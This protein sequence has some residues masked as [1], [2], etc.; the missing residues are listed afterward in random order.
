[1]IKIKKG[2]DLP[3][4]GHPEQT[5]YDGQKCTKVAVL[6]GDYVGMKPTIKVKVGDQVKKGDVLFIDKKFPEIHFTSPGAGKVL[7]VNRGKRRVFE[8]VVIEL[9]GS[10]GEVT[11]DS[12]NSSELEGLGLEKVKSNL[13]KS[14]LW[15]LLKTRPFSKV[16]DPS[17]EPNSIFINT[18]DTNPLAADPTAVIGEKK[19]AFINGLKVISNLT[20]GKKYLC[21]EAGVSI[22]GSELSFLDVKEFKGVHPA[23]NTGTHI[24]FIDPVSI[25]KTVWSIGYQSVISIGELFTTGKICV[26]RVVALSG[27]KVEKPRLVRTRCGAK[28]SE[29]L[30]NQLKSG[31][32]RIISGSVLNGRSA[33]S[34]FDYLG[35]FHN[36]VTVISEGKYREFLGWVMPGKNKFSVKNIFLSSIIPS[37]NFDFSTNTNG[38]ER[39]MVPIGSYEKVMPLDILPTFL[40][41]ALITLDTDYAQELGCLELDEEDLALCTFVC[42][43]KYEYGSILRANLNQIEKDG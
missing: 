4:M 36:Q 12:F 25:D 13:L 9:D 21:K 17:S 6:G 35:R 33:F 29:L 42:P 34:A 11:F 41:R 39:A 5:I 32:Y 23:G 20:K 26:D 27:S 10:E 16:P 40:L 22:P 24:H 1:M 2:L 15:T 28:L 37:R 30:V 7:E 3:I 43:S 14:G 18:M 38:G 19:E 31:D 8:S